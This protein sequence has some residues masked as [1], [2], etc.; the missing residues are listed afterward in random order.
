MKNKVI[1]FYGN[2]TV[3]QKVEPLLFRRGYF[4]F[5]YLSCANFEEFLQ[6]LKAAKAEC[7]QCIVLCKNQ[8]I[9][10]VLQAVV[11]PQDSL[12]LLFDQAVKL[13]SGQHRMLFVPSELDVEKF[14]DEFL[15]KREVCTFSVFGKSAAFM[16][17]I[18]SAKEGLGYKIITRS[19]LF[20]T[21]YC[22]ADVDKEW[23]EAVFGEGLLYGYSLADECKKFMRERGL[24]LAVAEQITAGGFSKLMGRFSNL[25]KSVILFK[26]DDFNSIG[27]KGELVREFGSVSNETSFEVCKGLLKTADV[28][29]SVLGNENGNVNVAVGNRDV[30][31][32]RTSHFEDENFADVACDLAL[33]RLYRFLK[34]NYE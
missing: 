19:Q 15:E 20:H 13:E 33:F 5:T 34:E 25:R 27:V 16:E 7:D 6:E 1:N 29:L 30:L 31:Y 21:V 17:K 22:P 14:L 26:E 2:H 8:L 3:A 32:N 12:S 10:D 23:L 9:D 11:S 28:V 4:D 18:L 24:S